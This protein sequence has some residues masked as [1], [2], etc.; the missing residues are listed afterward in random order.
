VIRRSTRKTRRARSI[1]SAPVAGTRASPTTARS[2]TLQGSRKKDRRWTTRRAASSSTKM[3][4]TIRS[5]AIST[6]PKVAIAEGLVSRPK[7]MA[8]RMISARITRSVRGSFNKRSSIVVSK[9]DGS[10]LPCH[11]REAPVL[12]LPLGCRAGCGRP[13]GKRGLSPAEGGARRLCDRR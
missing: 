11:H 8:L 3:A 10:A 6:G 5:M 2:N 9:S 1:D 12:T 4:R 13:T 7:V